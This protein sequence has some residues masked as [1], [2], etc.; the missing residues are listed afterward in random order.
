MSTDDA[1]LNA[2][3][4]QLQSMEFANA[5]TESS[6]TANVYHHANQDGPTSMDHANNALETVVNVQEKPALVPL[7]RLDSC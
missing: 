6:K 7:A 3:L 2:Q 5:P 1:Q 4:V